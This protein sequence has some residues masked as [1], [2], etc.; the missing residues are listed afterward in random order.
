[1]ASAR[2]HHLTNYLNILIPAV[3]RALCD[4]LGE[5]REAAAL[6]FDGLFSAVGSRAIDEI[7]P[8][9]IF[10]FLSENIFILFNFSSSQN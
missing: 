2:K 9:M 4:E 5:V 8:G 6:A 3:S 10:L 1:M 7:I